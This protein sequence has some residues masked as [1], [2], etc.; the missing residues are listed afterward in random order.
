MTIHSSDSLRQLASETCESRVALHLIWAANEIDRLNDTAARESHK[1][2]LAD[3]NAIADMRVRNRV[4]S[5]IAWHVNREHAD[6]SD[7]ELAQTAFREYARH[8]GRPL[9]DPNE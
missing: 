9:L 5:V 4:H 2:F 6:L 7:H 3:S 1:T 8:V